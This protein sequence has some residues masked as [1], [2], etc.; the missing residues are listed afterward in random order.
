M[1]D[2]RGPSG[3]REAVRQWQQIFPGLT[4]EISE[5][6]N[7]DGPDVLCIGRVTGDAAAS[8]VHVDMDLAFQLKVVDGTAVEIGLFSASR[9][10]ALEAVG[11]GVRE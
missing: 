7:P 8:G 9:G 3:A 6:I 11:T 2:F 4:I 1:E 5:F 10:E